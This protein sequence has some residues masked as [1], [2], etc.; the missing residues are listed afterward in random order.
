MGATV[1]T[2]K[3]ANPASSSRPTIAATAAAF[4]AAVAMLSITGLLPCDV[5]MT[6]LCHV[7]PANQLLDINAVLAAVARGVQIEQVG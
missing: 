5:A 1:S 4:T 3:H 2:V 6:S 7:W